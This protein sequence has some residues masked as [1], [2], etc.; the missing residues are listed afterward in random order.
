VAFSLATFFWPHKR[1]YARPQGG[2]PS[3]S[4]LQASSNR[5]KAVNRDPTPVQFYFP[6][7]AAGRHRR[8]A[9]S[10]GENGSRLA[11]WP[12]IQF[13]RPPL[14]IQ[15]MLA[16]GRYCKWMT[17]QLQTKRHY[18][19]DKFLVHGPRIMAHTMVLGVLISKCLGQEEM[20]AVHAQL[21]NKVGEQLRFLGGTENL[22]YAAKME[23]AANSELD[24]LF[25]FASAIKR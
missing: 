21:T 8:P 5:L 4:K 18:M 24:T 16:M 13:E 6:G 17:N 22:D 20:N 11:G 1:K 23:A 15:K 14:I 12:V 10:A 9:G 19:N 25:A 7:N 2:S 3:P